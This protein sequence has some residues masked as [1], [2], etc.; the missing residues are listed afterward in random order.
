MKVI[1]IFGSPGAG[2]STT[3]AGLFHFMKKNNFN[4]ELVTEF[5]K[6]L[7]WSKRGKCLKDQFYVSAKQ[8][9]RLERLKN[10]V[11]FVITDSPLFLGII[12][13]SEN[14]YSLFEPL[15]LQIFNSYNN[16]NIFL[17]RIKLYNPIGRNQTES[18]SNA[19]SDLIEFRLKQYNIEYKKMDAVDNCY[20]MIYNSFIKE[21]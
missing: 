7:T 14:Y 20:E 8:N 12:Y 5:A 19:L 9:H 15:L 4:V 6:E 11:D 21:V 1:N 17:K 13:A 16:L 3:A 18:E 10:Q 2:K